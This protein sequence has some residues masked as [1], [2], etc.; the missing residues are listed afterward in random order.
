MTQK[1]NEIND[2]KNQVSKEKAYSRSWED[3]CKQLDNYYKGIYN[4]YYGGG[5]GGGYGYGGYHY[6][7]LTK[8]IMWFSLLSVFLNFNQQK[9]MNTKVNFMRFLFS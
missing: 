7:S 9:I 8:E 3:Y 1:Q 6:W 4:S 5:Y 2:L